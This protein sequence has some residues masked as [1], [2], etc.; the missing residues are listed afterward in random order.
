[1][2]KKWI[3]A[4]CYHFLYFSLQFRSKLKLWIIKFSFYLLK[5]SLAYD[6]RS[7]DVFSKVMCALALREKLCWNPQNVEQE[8]DGNLQALE[9]FAARR[10]VNNI[11]PLIFLWLDIYSSLDASS[12]ILQEKTGSDTDWKIIFPNN[13]GMWSSICLTSFIT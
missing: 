9:H 3:L 12:N 11:L 8:T 2:L 5:H 7:I 10:A 4:T 6:F 13:A 1:M